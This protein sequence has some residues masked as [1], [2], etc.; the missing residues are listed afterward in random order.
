MSKQQKDQRREAQRILDL[1]AKY[2]VPLPVELVQSP[3]FAELRMPFAEIAAMMLAP[4]DKERSVPALRDGAR[5]VHEHFNGFL[6][7]LPTQVRFEG[8]DRPLE[9]ACKTGCNHCCTFRVTLK[10]PEALLIANYLRKK[11]SPEELDDLMARIGEFEKATEGL[12]LLEQGYRSIMCPLNVDALCRVYTHRPLNCSGYHSFSLQACIDDRENPAAAVPV[13]SDAYRRMVHALH[14]QA[15][16]C[17][18]VALGLEAD[19]LEF[20][21][22]LRIALT[23]PDA[24]EKYLR[25]EPVFAD[26]NRPDLREAVNKDYED[27]QLTR[28]RMAN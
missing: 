18:L 23:D 19:D 4:L 8:Q 2:Q 6:D 25:G 7:K 17:A 1:M 22:A 5:A 12:S 26:A 24:G 14:G 9:L 3:R 28:L 20:V 16:E 10:A 21:P 15:M 13:P 11:L 27:R